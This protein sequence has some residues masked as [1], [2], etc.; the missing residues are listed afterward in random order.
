ME[1]T[2]II[3]RRTEHDPNGITGIEDVLYRASDGMRIG[4]SIKNFVVSAV[5]NEDVPSRAWSWAFLDEPSAKRFLRE[6]ITAKDLK[7]R[8]LKCAISIEERDGDSALV[9]M[10]SGSLELND[11][12]YPK[13]N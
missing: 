2:H 1:Y 13:L 8:G 4:S 7:K 10:P 5:D 6:Q 9:K 11:K 3:V 12:G